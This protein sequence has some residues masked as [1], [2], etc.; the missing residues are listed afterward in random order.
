VTVVTLPDEGAESSL[1]IVPT[2]WPSPMTALL[3]LERLTKNVSSGA[4][5]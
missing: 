1:R 3:A 5:V 2:P 4:T